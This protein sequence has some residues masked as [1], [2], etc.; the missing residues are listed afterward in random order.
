[1]TAE[2]YE[3]SEGYRISRVLN[4]CWQ[5]SQ[6]HS[7]DRQ[8]DFSDI[9]KAFYELKDLGFTTFDCAD[10]YTGAEE[11]IGSF[12]SE[13]KQSGDYR[14]EDIQIHTKYVP[15][16]E[17]LSK[18]DFAFTESIIDRSLMRLNRDILDVVQFHW[19]DYDVPGMIE[20]AGHLKTLKEKGKIRN[21]AVTNFDSEHLAMLVDAGIPVVSCQTQYSLLDRRTEKTLQKYCSE[22][23]IK[24]ICYGTLAGGFLAERYLGRTRES[25]IPETRSQV[26]YLQ[27]IDDS[28]GWDGYQKL[29]KLLSAIGKA[30][31][32]TA[33]QA[34]V[35]FI[36]EQE[37]VAAAII[38]I[39][40]SAHVKDNDSIFSFRLSEEE[41]AS[42]RSLIY[43][44]P[45]PDGEPFELERTPG[46]KYRSIMH[47][48]IN[49]DEQS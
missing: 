46:S 23:G 22:H 28:L 16:L 6:G 31:H 27:I 4:G 13:L 3:L 33:S 45:T 34:A 9:R 41:T 40:S 29:L 25:V 2:K 30:H 37:D 43:S 32:V 49:E 38:G 7:L 10:I 15:D 1:M 39:R 44:Y 8:L 19:W 18:V 24:L 21:I 17:Y 5:L 12:I 11:F 35:R 48:N 20:T 47:M 36:L 42:L 26:K 14:E